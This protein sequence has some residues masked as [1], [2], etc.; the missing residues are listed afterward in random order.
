MARQRFIIKTIHITAIAVLIAA[1]MCRAGWATQL[2]QHD[3]AQW[4][5]FIASAHGHF[6]YHESMHDYHDGLSDISSGDHSLIHGALALDHQVSLTT[7]S[8]L[9]QAHFESIYPLLVF[10]PLSPYQADL[11]R[12]PRYTIV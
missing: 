3:V 5:E 6:H 2:A 1:A 10:Q 4:E 7:F 12:P 11:Y 8:E 9:I